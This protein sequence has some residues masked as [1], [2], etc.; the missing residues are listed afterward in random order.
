MDLILSKLGAKAEGNTHPFYPLMLPHGTIAQDKLV[1]G[2]QSK[3]KEEV[4]EVMEANT[5]IPVCV[6][7]QNKSVKSPS[8]PD[9]TSHLRSDGMP[10]SIVASC[11]TEINDCLLYTSDAADE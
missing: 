7:T 6:K 9:A 8:G 10:G 5:S 4:A 1:D 2:A 11:K 3:I